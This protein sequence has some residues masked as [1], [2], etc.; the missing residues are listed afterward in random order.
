MFHVALGEFYMIL[1]HAL[2]NK[3]WISFYSIYSQI[4]L[5]E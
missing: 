1:Q 3:L 4:T 5:F 2:V